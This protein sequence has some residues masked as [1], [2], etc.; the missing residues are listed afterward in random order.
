MHNPAIQATPATVS[1]KELREWED[2]DEY[3]S[4]NR[5]ER[6][7]ATARAYHRLREAADY[8]HELASWSANDVIAEAMGDA[9]GRI[10]DRLA[11]AL[12]PTEDTA[13][14]S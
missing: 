7:I 14:P 2:D 11:T 1:E 4:W 8:C 12:P 9:L 3:L 5:R 13:V 6:L 10:R